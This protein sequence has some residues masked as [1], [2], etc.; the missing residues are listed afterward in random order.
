MGLGSV[1]ASAASG[2]RGRKARAV[3]AIAQKL[4]DGSFHYREFKALTLRPWGS[5][6][7]NHV[8]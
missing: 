5:V 2:A 7:P 4:R 8:T 1:D 3:M 6:S